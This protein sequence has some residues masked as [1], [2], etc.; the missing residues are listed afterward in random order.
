MV[1]FAS[2]VADASKKIKAGSKVQMFTCVVILALL[3]CQFVNIGETVAIANKLNKVPLDLKNIQK[4]SK[5]AKNSSI[6][7]VILLIILTG[8]IVACFRGIK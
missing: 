5:V 1:N 2:I 3:I 8:C 4:Q 6:A 7:N